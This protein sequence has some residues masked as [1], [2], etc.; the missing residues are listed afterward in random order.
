MFDVKMNSS[1]SFCHFLVN[2]FYN[3]VINYRT[4]FDDLS[5]ASKV[6]KTVRTV[7]GLSFTIYKALK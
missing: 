5:L 1:M 6:D 7:F 4:S 2:R 3:K